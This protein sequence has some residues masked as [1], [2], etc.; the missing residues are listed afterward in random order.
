[1]GIQPLLT[2]PGPP[3]PS[4][5]IKNGSAVVG[6]VAVVVVVVVAAAGPPG[7]CGWCGGGAGGARDRLP[8]RVCLEIEL[9]VA[10]FSLQHLLGSAA[11]HLEGCRL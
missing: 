1:M 4:P 8:R 10:P 2:S 5:R 9:L 3:H 7:A 11:R 6:L